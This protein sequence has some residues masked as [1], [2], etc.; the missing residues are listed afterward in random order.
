MTLFPDAPASGAPS[1]APAEAPEALPDLLGALLPAGSPIPRDSAVAVLRRHLGRI[2]GRV[3]KAFEARDIQGLAAARWLASLTDEVMR[4]AH[5]YTLA[6]SPAH[7]GSEAGW[8]LV[9]TG[10]YG[11]GVLAPFSDIDLLFLTDTPMGAQGKR[12]VEFMLYLLWDLGVKVGHATR[13][14][15]ECI[16]DAK[17]DA[18][19]LTALLDARPIAGEAA[20]FE[21]FERDFRKARERWGLG[22]FLAAKRAERSTRHARYGDSPYLVEP[23]LKEGRGGLRDLQTLYWIARYAFNVQKMPELVHPVGHGGALLTEREARQIRRAWNFLWTVRFHLHLVSGR[24]EER[25]TFDLQPVVGARMGY[26][27][28]GLQDGVERFMKHFFLNARDIA[29]FTRILEPAIER[30]SLGPPAVV[31]A[32]DR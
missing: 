17:R 13:T 7:D 12:S 30:A 8:A 26:T 24:A 2:Q 19:V 11:R 22:T 16:E 20:V 18:T 9:A 29:R 23:H 3:Q 5:A 14:C 21:R 10:G 27:R 31:P 4:A 32:S 1:E 6:Q 25:L 28:H 15:A